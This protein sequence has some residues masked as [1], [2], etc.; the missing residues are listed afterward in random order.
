[1]G[2]RAQAL[3]MLRELGNKRLQADCLMYMGDACAQSPQVSRGPS[4]VI[5]SFGRGEVLEYCGDITLGRS[6]AIVTFGRSK[7]IAW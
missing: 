3:D 7:A 1:M 4:M 2:I 6:M 5:V